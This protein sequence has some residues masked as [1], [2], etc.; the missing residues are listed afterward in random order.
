MYV[1]EQYTLPSSWGLR[2]DNVLADSQA[3]AIDQPVQIHEM[4]IL[5]AADGT[6]GWYRASRVA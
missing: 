3:I 5:Y 1:I 4:H 2:S 6:Q